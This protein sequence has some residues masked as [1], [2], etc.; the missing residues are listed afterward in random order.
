MNIKDVISLLQNKKSFFNGHPDTYRFVIDH[1]G[2]KQELG[3]VV[4]VK[5]IKPSGEEAVTSMTFVEQ[6][7]PFLN[8]ISNI[9]NERE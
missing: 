8:A 5:M 2:A 7:M 6:D 9:L 4:E 1:F 3:T